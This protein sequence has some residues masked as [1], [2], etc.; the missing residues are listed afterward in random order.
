MQKI[1]LN[2]E[3]VLPFLKARKP[4]NLQKEISRIHERMEQE[5]EPGSEFL[6]WRR[7]PSQMSRH[8][9]KKINETAKFVQDQT[10]VFISIGIGGSYLGAKAAVEFVNHSF[11]NQLSAKGKKAPEIYFAGQNIS[12][13]YL[14]DLID[15][16]KGKRICLNVISKS[17]TTTEPAIAFRLLKEVLEKRHGKREARKRI[18]VT[19]DQKKGALKKLAAKEGYTSFIIPDDVGGRFSVLTPVGLLPMAVSGINIVDL[20][21]GAK[22]YEEIA[23][24]PDMKSNPAYLYAVTRNLLYRKRKTT[25]ILSSFHPSLHYFSEWWKQLAGESEGKNHKGIYPSIADFTTDL[26]SMGQWIQEGK[27]NI[28]ETFLLIQQSN[29]SL[30]IPRLKN[31]DDGLNYIAGRSLEYV[32]DKAY[33]GTALAH[34]KGEVPN[35]AITIPDR[36]P[37]SLGQLFYFFEC[38]IAMSGYLLKVNPFD[39][40]GVEF[41][42]KNMFKLLKKPGF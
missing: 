35:M 41:Y 39:Q 38:A 31:D 23:F 24:N 6:G 3:N 8:H 40:P 27:R 10:D 33:R 36:S 12:S 11:F 17:G 28:F 21:K 18:I 13:D 9:L 1:T 22:R 19:T 30:S 15:I 34:K 14:A 25:E 16:L 26:H 32:N 5:K 42:K 20:I 2:I 29:R 7:L 4:F 37:S